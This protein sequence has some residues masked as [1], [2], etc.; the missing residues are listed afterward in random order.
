MASRAMQVDIEPSDAIFGRS[1][2]GD[3]VTNRFSIPWCVRWWNDDGSRHVEHGIQDMVAATRFDAESAVR[4]G[5]LRQFQW[6]ARPLELAFGD[7][8]RSATR[9]IPNYPP[10]VPRVRALRERVIEGVPPS[11]IRA[12]LVAAGASPLTVAI[13]FLYAFHLDIDDLEDVTTWDQRIAARETWV[14]PLELQQAFERGGS[15]VDALHV[16]YEAAGS[17]MPLFKALRE[18]FGLELGDTK[19]LL[20]RACHRDPAFDAELRLAMVRARA[21]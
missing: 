16:Q 6:P 17:S 8:L 19:L 12:E 3:P 4:G 15:V 1:A 11:A 10:G 7:S 20:E 5:L 13:A 18:A 9:Y 2:G 21:T 14:W